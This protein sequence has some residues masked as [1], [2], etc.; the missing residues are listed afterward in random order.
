MPDGKVSDGTFLMVYEYEEPTGFF[1]TKDTQ[2]VRDVE[3]WREWKGDV[4]EIRLPEM[5]REE[6]VERCKGVVWNGEIRGVSLV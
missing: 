4:D 3:E 1:P 2:V 6:V 5:T